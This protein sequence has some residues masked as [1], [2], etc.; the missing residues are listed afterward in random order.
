MR[1]KIVLL[2]LFIIVFLSIVIGVIVTRNVS[3][4]KVVLKIGDI[5]VTESE[6]LMI[7]DYELRAKVLAM[8]DAEA[9]EP[10]ETVYKDGTLRDYAMEETCKRI[11]RYKAEQILFDKYDVCQWQFET[12]EKDYEAYLSEDSGKSMYGTQGFTK[13]DYFVHQYSNYRLQ[14]IQKLQKERNDEGELYRYYLK[15]ADDY[16]EADT[17]VFD[18]YSISKEVTDAKELLKS[19]VE[20]E[21]TAEVDFRRVTLDGETSKYEQNLLVTIEEHLEELKTEG[22]E[23]FLENEAQWIF[24]RTITYK[25]GDVR[26]FADCQS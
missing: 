21:P 25:E 12:F 22:K 18:Y 8:A 14:A 23:L 5:G 9:K 13:Y 2:I 20:G 11:L 16:R 4:D 6:F 24:V 10:L 7:Y 1:K 19:C 15:Y 26:E 17:Y 3:D